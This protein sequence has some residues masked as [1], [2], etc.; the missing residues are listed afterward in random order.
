MSTRDIA[1]DVTTLPGR[2]AVRLGPFAATFRPRVVAVPLVGL[3][4]LV[5]VAALNIGLG[6]AHLDVIDVLRTLAG[7]GDRRETGIVFD[8]RLPRTLTGILVGAALGLAGAIFQTIA[9]NPLASPDILGITW[10]AGVGAVT[11][12]VVGGYRGQV[13]GVAASLGVP[14]AGL[15]GGL[16]AGLLLYLLSWRRGIDGFRMVLIGIGLAAVGYNLVYWLLTVGD[17]DDA[18]RAT[19]WIVG[20]LG[21]VGW[22]SVGPVAL[23]L[24][25]L[26]PA[27]L[28]CAHTIGGLQFGDETARGLGIRVDAARGTLLLLAAG[29]AAVATAAAGP[30]TFVALATPQIALRLARTAQPPLV[31]SLVLGALLTVGADL[32][33]RQAPGA[34]DLPVGV[35][36][37]ILGAPYLIYLFVRTRRKVRV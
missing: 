9:R 6:S 11:V 1:R 24:A 12:I 25:L 10:G 7:G 28:L 19:T 13:S 30:I 17:V 31:G 32:A 21:N 37:A 23:A 18:T 8:L 36:T 4:L 22:E 15:A 27:T 20:N 35:L 3:V 26:V 34:A 16:L 29:L 5:L 14:L 2:K 33:V